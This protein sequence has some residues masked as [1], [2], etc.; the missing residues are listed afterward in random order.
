LH[1][2][3]DG[4]GFAFIASIIASDLRGMPRFPMICPP[5]WRP[6]SIA[7]PMPSTVA[8]ADFAMAAKPCRARSFASEA[9]ALTLFMDCADAVPRG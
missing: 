5:I 1:S 9:Y 7:M 2:E 3:G 8:L 6:F 4:S